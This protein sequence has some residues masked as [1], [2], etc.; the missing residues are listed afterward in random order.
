MNSEQFV[1]T[2][3]EVASHA[4]SRG[5]VA[6]LKKPPGRSPDLQ[7]VTLANW[8]NGLGSTDRGTVGRIIEM[9]TDQAVYNVLLVLDGLLAIEPAG[10]KG[11][12]ELTL[13]NEAGR[14][15]MNPSTSVPLSTLF[16]TE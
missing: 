9:A 14:Q 10:P 4:A 3:K 6:A 2:L 13:E 5:I 8:Y 1:A 12:L 7:L 11:R 16:K 15:V